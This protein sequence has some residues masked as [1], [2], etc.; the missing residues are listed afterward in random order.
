MEVRGERADFNGAV[1]VHNRTEGRGGVQ[2][3]LREH[4]TMEDRMCRVKRRSRKVQK[5]GRKEGIGL[6]E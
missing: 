4:R 1:R 2:R 5:T 3:A 6:C